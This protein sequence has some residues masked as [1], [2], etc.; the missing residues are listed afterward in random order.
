MKRL[1]IL[2]AAC[3]TLLSVFSF[4]AFA[5]IPMKKVLSRVSV[6]AEGN[7]RGLVDTIGFPHVTRQMDAIAKLS[8]IAEKNLIEENQKKFNLPDNEGFIF[9]IC[10]HD[11]YTLAGRTAVHIQ[12]FIKAKRV[13]L[14]G[15]AH[16]SEAF[17]IRNK[18]I[19]GDFK[20]WR[21][22]Y[23]RV[24]ISRL[25]EKILSRLPKR[26]YVV[27]RTVVETEHSLEALVPFLQ[28]FNKEVEIVPVLVP[29]TEWE[30]ENKL[31]EDLAR[32][33]AKMVEENHWKLGKDLAVLCSS[34]GMHYGDYG[35]SY[36]N[37]HPFGCN[38]DG[39]KKA[40]AYDSLL[41][42]NYLTGKITNEKLHRLFGKII[43][44]R[45][46]S[47]YKVTWCGRFSITL[48]ANFSERLVKKVLGRNLT[49]Y[50]LRHSSGVQE[51]WIPVRK[52][53]MGIT[54][55]VN[56]H[57]FVTYFSVGFK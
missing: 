5:Q 1:G 35:W 32:V 53:N 4:T 24:K 14:I 38:P 45:N 20:Y 7:L 11:D 39:Y 46:I 10:P 16:W 29:F 30:K 37:Y 48:A 54:G 3:S 15:N 40:M 36:Y 25:R 51:A 57:H 43:D 9:G 23:G 42:T 31:G 27:N 13:I 49:G 50:F 56:L 28:Y 52:M 21:G 47:N 17:G 33:V 55:D 44:E 18:L 26:D 34:D 6:P 41:V 2:F 19:F 22:P 8:L 12:K